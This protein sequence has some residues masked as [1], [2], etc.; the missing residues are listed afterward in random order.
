MLLWLCQ[1]SGDNPWKFFVCSWK[2]L[3]G[4]ASN[5]TEPLTKGHAAKPLI[6]SLPQAIDYFESLLL[7]GKRWKIRNGFIFQSHKIRLSVSPLNSGTNW[8]MFYFT[9]LSYFW[10]LL[11][12]SQDQ[13][14]GAFNILAGDLFGHIW[15]FISYFA[16]ERIVIISQSPHMVHIFW[17]PGTIFSVFFLNNFQWL[18]HNF[19]T[20]PSPV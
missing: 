18:V 20:S 19:L 4:T 2:C 16:D 9:H 12:N 11:I 10:N 1:A 3:L 14:A 8:A 6:W 13:V 7:A 17:L 15:K 5:L